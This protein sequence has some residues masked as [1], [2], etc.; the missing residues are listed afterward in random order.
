MIGPHGRWR[1]PFAGGFLTM[2]LLV[3]TAPHAAGQGL[4]LTSKSDQPVVIEADK[5]V[6]WR[7]TEQVYVARGNATAKRGETTVRADVLTAHYRKGQKSKT[8]VWKV[9]AVGRVRISG[10]K[11]TI[12]GQH[13]VYMV[14]TGVFILTGNNLKLTTETQTVTARDKLEYRSKQKIAEIIGNATMVEGDKKV[15]ADKF[16]AYLKN[17]GGKTKL[18]NVKAIGN[19]VITT[20]SEIAKGKRADYNA[21]TEIAT[22]SGDVKLTRGANQLNGDRAEV[23][24]K[25]GVSKLL[26]S[27]ASD[28]RVGGT[29][30]KSGRV[31]ILLVPREEDESIKKGLPETGL[32][33]SVPKVK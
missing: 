27:R 18:R 9:T 33:T 11:Q 15:R 21:E 25:T 31:R 23:N 29:S 8:Q 3:C 16:I 6:E 19:V 26:A 28:K 1:L 14:E 7:K 13:G 30:G 24:L 20:Q 22:L 4:G 5:S 10:P 2:A 17:D 12:T 32:K